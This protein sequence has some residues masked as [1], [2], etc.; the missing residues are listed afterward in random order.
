[1]I[2]DYIY[3]NWDILPGII[4]GPVCIYILVTL[5]TRI[6][7]LKSFSQ[8][9][10]FDFTMTIAMGSLIASSVIN[11][12]PSLVIGAGLITTLFILNYLTSYFRTQ[13]KFFTS[14]IDNQPILLMWEGELLRENMTKARVSEDEIRAKLREANVLNRQEVRAVILET[15]GDVSV[16]H[17]KEK[18]TVDEYLLIGV[19]K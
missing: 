8:M 19:Q 5:Y 10:G 6:F 13:S 2:A 18:Q 3:N 16:L 11:D 14:M 9:T 1:M 4:I 12:S 7:G 15:T 17:G